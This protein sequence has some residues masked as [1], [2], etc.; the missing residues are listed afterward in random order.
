MRNNE[1]RN[2]MKKNISRCL[3]VFCGILAV[4]CN[5]SQQ[6][7]K[8]ARD[9]LH[10]VEQRYKSMKTFK[11]EA[12][13]NSTIKSA[14]KNKNSSFVISYARKEPAELRIEMRGGQMGLTV[15]SN[16]NTTWTYLPSSGEYKKQQSSLVQTAQNA[17]GQISQ[18]DFTDMGEQLT[19]TYKSITKDLKKAEVVGSK[20]V[21]MTD[22]SQEQAY[23]IKATYN[24]DTGMKDMKISATTYLIDKKTHLVLQQ[25]LNLSATEDSPRSPLT[26]YQT[27]NLK[28]ADLHPSFADSTFEFN[29]PA[30]AKEVK[31]FAFEGQQNNSGYDLVGKKA[32]NFDLK[33]YQGKELSLNDLKGKVVV[34]DFWAT[35]CG[36]C[37]EAHPHLQKIYDEYKDDGLV[38][39][40]INSESKKKVHRYMEEN[41]YTFTNVMDPDQSV[42]IDYGVNAIPSVF[43]I[44]RKGMVASHLIGYQPESALRKAIKKAGL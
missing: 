40:G 7:E 29:P 38:V 33:T 36:P 15:V 19:E 3:I 6:T 34:L 17:S 42:S 12:E 24:N 37:R 41:G 20:T 44:N 16:G 32:I 11:L 35:W 13:L 1:G 31:Q 25:S 14:G 5:N 30:S 21:K 39:L 23:K 18:S 2:L 22:G 43:V 28:A 26:M 4:A 9:I 27:V 8:K 10:S